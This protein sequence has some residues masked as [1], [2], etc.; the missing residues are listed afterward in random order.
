MKKDIVTIMDGIHRMENIISSMKEMA[1]QSKADKQETNLYGTLLVALT[2]THNKCKHIS[3]VYLNGKQYTTIMDH[4][5][6]IFNAN[7]QKQRIEQV[8][9]VIINNAMDELIKKDDFEDR[10][11]DIT[12]EKVDEKTKLGLKIMQVE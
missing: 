10:R 7:V 12:I 9:I 5:D 8:W 2:M 3:K 4:N 1:S 11:L 6:E